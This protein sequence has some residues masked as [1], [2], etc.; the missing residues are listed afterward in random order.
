MSAT[1]LAIVLGCSEIYLLGV[2]HRMLHGKSHFWQSW[3]KNDRPVRDGKGRD[4]MPCQ[5]QQ[6]RVF[7]SNMNAFKVVDKWAKI[8]GA[9]IYNCSTVSKLETFPMVSLDEALQ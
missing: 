6:G 7:K 3:D 5:R 4:F 1:D 2:D 9:K 8:N